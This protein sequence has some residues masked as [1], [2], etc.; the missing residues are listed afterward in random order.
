MQTFYSLF[1][2]HQCIDWLDRFA[3]QPRLSLTIL[4][5]LCIFY[6]ISR[7]NTFHVFKS[8]S[9]IYL[10]F[11]SILFSY[12]VYINSCMLSRCAIYIYFLSIIFSWN[13]V[14]PSVFSTILPF[15]FY[16]RRHKY[17]PIID[18]CPLSHLV[19]LLLSFDL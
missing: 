1:F 18:T 16:N 6:P 7:F 4:F 15:S 5:N 8:M 3:F 13:L 12:W 2:Y 11:L 9:G 17:P 10:E 14:F 19:I